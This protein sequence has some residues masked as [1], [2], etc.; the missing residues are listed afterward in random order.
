MY[1]ADSLID[2]PQTEIQ[3]AMVRA[4]WLIEAS[5]NSN[6]AKWELTMAAEKSF[7]YIDE[8]EKAIAALLR[9]G[10]VLEFANATRP[11]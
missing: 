6:A 7:R 5:Y 1:E 3:E 2:H 4:K 10:R 11:Y 8:C 9:A